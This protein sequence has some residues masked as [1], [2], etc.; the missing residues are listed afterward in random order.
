LDLPESFL[1]VEGGPHLVV[2]ALQNN[3]NRIYQ[4]AVVVDDED[5]LSVIH[6]LSSPATI[7]Y[8]SAV[9]RRALCSVARES[10]SPKPNSPPWMDTSQVAGGLCCI[11]PI[12][13][14]KEAGF[15]LWIKKGARA[16]SV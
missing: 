9:T 12:K 10:P 14:S 1:P 2:L 3:A 7:L 8:K 6:V 16:S 5:T 4:I 11:N 13:P 15:R